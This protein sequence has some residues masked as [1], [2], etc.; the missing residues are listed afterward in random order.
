MKISNELI[1]KY[2]RNECTQEES[3]FVEAWL[4]SGESDEA[5]QLPLGENK[6]AHKTMMWDE[7]EKTLPPETNVPVL[8]KKPFLRNTF[9]TGAVAASLVICLTFIGFYKLTGTKTTEDTTFVTVNNTSSVNV[10]HLEANGYHIAVGT[11][12][13]TKINNETGIIDLTGSLLI[14][15]KK[16]I[17]L[18][19]AGNKEEM[20]FKAGQ[21][22]IILKG[23]DGHDK[24]IVINE[25]NVMDLP[26]V[27]QKQIINEFQI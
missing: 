11:N 25:K 1:E 17:R 26:P 8:V 12:T 13:S 9:W 19:F 14:R 18:L 27:L 24:I 10:K 3:D 2:H 6:A 23:E 15:P 21:T 5:L 16:D 7:I 4:F 20:V 22:Y